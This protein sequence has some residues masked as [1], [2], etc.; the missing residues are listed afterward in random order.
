M[1]QMTRRECATGLLL[2]AATPAATATYTLENESIRIEI[3]DNARVFTNKLVNETVA[4]PRPDF[5]LEFD[6]GAIAASS[7]LSLTVTA[8]AK[9]RLE[10]MLAAS[11]GPFAGLEVRVEYSLAP[12]KAYLRKQIRVR[13][14]TGATARLMRADLDN[15]EG[16]RRD[17]R[18]MRAD[19]LPYGSH[20]IF[21]DSLWAGVEF[22]A[23]FNQ[24]SANGFVLRSRPGRQPIGPDWLVLHPTVVGVSEPGTVRSAFLRYIDDVRLAPPRLVACYNSWWTLP[25]RIGRA[26]HLALAR[27][28]AE[29]LHGGHDVFFDIFTTD[30]GWT[31]PKSIWEID[32]KNLPDGFTEIRRI[33][34]SAG[35][36][37]G[38]WM[39]PSGLYPRSLDYDWAEKNG[40]VVLRYTPAKKQPFRTGV[41]LADPNYRNKTKQQLR[42]LIREE[43]F[44]HIKYDGFTAREERPHHDLPGGDDSVEPLAAHC[45]ELIQASKEANPDLV[46]EPTCINS[47]ANYISPWMIKYSDTLWGNSGG[48]CPR[49]L[50]PAPD[51]REAHTTA[52]EYYILSSTDEIWLPQNALQYFD[53]V[54][55][56]EGIGF[57]NHAAMAVGR[58][59]FFLATYLNPKFMSEVDWRVYAGLL[60]WA[61]GNRDLLRNTAIL[62]SRVEKGEPYAYA[63]WLGRRGVIAVRNPSNESRDYVLD[64][65]ASGAPRDLTDA[66]CYTQYPY[67]SGIE[68]NIAAKG[69]ITLRLA[70][71]ELI[72]LEIVPRTE[73]REPVVIGARWYAGPAGSTLITPDWGRDTVRV[74]QPSGVEVSHNVNG[75]ARGDVGGDLVS[76]SMRKLPEAEWLR[77][78]DRPAPTVG[79]EIE[80]SVSV[81]AAA[82]GGKVLLLAEF[83]G[84]QHHP[85]TCVGTV[86]GK[87]VD[88]KVSSSQ[89]HI[90]YYSAAPDSYWKGVLPYESEWTWYICEVAP[91]KSVVHFSGAAAD[92]NTRIGLWLWADF[93]AAARQTALPFAASSPEMPE[94][95]PH[96][97]RHGVCLKPAETR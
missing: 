57:P 45:L 21:S 88:V 28:L 95:E 43:G 56:D 38:L 80:C 6:N 53:I 37:L 31:D 46:S 36:K 82:S 14:R 3:T 63:H 26:Q 20:P 54:H 70:P 1:S 17:W 92:P 75:G 76:Q 27:D 7:D 61:R 32:R 23:A 18:S 42:R 87:A 10:L 11:G 96:R 13:S 22:V 58:G 9:D 5:R 25:L 59:R 51:Y 86:N 34:E 97:E 78:K 90:G 35:G 47:P 64:L 77:E 60:R 74:L 49:G 24:Y 29:K 8:R 83:P 81:P 2:A 94:W 40:Y 50:G 44:A 16:V 85:S 48:D 52:R 30:E 93:D 91:G 33:V 67:R 73:L 15:W 72:F 41:S 84:R 89:G 68:S 4:L 71:W 65:R 69:S 55:C 62:R 79:F 66:V 12:G 19:R 39:S